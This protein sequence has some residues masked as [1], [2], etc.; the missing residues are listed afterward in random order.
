MKSAVTHLAIILDGNRRW[1]KEHGLPTLEG[2]RVGY[3]RVKEI[4]DACLDRGI[5]VLSVFAF[6]TENWDRTTEE[7]GYLMD[8]LEGAL[9]NDLHFFRDRGVRLRILGRRE[10]LRPSIL[11]AIETAEQ[12]T[13]HS[14]RA[15]L[16]ICLNY[17]GRPEIVD[18]CKKLIA[19]GVRAEDVTEA[20]LTARMYWPE[21][22][23]PDLVI[24]TSG[25]ERLSGF[26][27]WETAYS[28]IY[29]CVTSWPDFNEHELDLALESYASR[30]RRFGK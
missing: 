11:R 19:D 24:R 1:A 14:I 9:I 16:C 20:S 13:A 27:T 15:T 6:S 8:L 10:R 5:A 28:E 7:V 26:L 3:D 17:G 21:M 2:H 22:P 29:W 30:Q 18:A 25:E 12:E 4:A 23:A